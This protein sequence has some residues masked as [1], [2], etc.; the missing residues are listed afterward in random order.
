MSRTTVLLADLPPMLEDM[1]SSVLQE[2][3]ALRVIR[4]G[5]G[6]LLDAAVAADADVVVT[7]RTDP[8]DI[9][10]FDPRLAIAAR[11]S[12]LALSLDGTTACLHA[13]RP[14]PRKIDDVSADQILTAIAQAASRGQP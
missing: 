13:P 14:A 1:V 11:M 8:A 9:A 12:V 10:S 5:K 4:G 3:S 7:A 6:S 2:E